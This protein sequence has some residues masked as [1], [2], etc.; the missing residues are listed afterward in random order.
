MI[1]LGA[2][3]VLAVI[4]AVGIRCCR[5]RR[6]RRQRDEEDEGEPLEPLLIPAEFF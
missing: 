3:I 1:G 6:A 2:V 4:V 5:R